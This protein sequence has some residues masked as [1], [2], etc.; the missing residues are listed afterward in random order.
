MPLYYMKLGTLNRFEF[1]YLK[2]QKTGMNS[3]I[4]AKQ[5]R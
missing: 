4:E 5:M 3:N 1:K 2:G